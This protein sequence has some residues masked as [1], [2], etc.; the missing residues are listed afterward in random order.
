MQ[1]FYLENIFLKVTINQRGAELASVLSKENGQE[2]LWNADERY[3]KR[4]APVLFP[5]VG[6]LKNGRVTVG[7]Q[8]YY[9]SQHGFARDMD[10]K[11]VK[12]PDGKRILFRL[13]E[14]EDTLAR[15]P[16]RFALEIEYELDRYRLTTTWRVIN[17]DERTIHFQIGG[18]PAF[19]CPLKRGERQQDYYLNFDTDKPLE[20]SLLSE[21]GLVESDGNILENDGGL[22]RVDEHMFDR[23]ALIFE[24]SQASKVSLCKPDGMSYISVAFDA[25]LFGLW[26]PAGKGAPFICIEPWYGRA[27]REDFTGNIEDREYDNRLEPGEIF[28]TSYSIEVEV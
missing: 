21:N 12:Q 22:V 6:S 25:P 23:D 3:W 10:F 7:G 5:I 14:D 11:M 16:Y 18:H 24:N 19:M 26:S 27:D 13:E 9:M 28:E 4:S 20:Y 2:Y 15:Y 1:R 17:T 8:D